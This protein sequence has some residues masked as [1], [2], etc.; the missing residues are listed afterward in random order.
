LGEGGGGS[1]KRR[2]E[3]GREEREWRDEEIGEYQYASV[4]S[5]GSPAGVQ[6][7]VILVVVSDVGRRPEGK[8]GD[9]YWSR[10]LGGQSREVHAAVHQVLE[11]GRGKMD[12]NGRAMRRGKATDGFE[13]R[14]LFVILADW[15]GLPT[16]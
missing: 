14:S 10:K 5:S 2:R 3:E 4:K 12:A 13:I 7:L 1:R 9:G 8:R 11:T 15:R 6:T 16:Y